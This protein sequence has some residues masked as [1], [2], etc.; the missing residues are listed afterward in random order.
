ML[1]GILIGWLLRNRKGK[2]WIF[3]S[4]L[5]GVLVDFS[6]PFLVPFF[7]SL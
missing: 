7:C 4:I 3:A 6:V 2:E 1:A 5:H